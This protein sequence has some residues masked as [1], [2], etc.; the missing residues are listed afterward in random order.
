VDLDVAGGGILGIAEF[1]VEKYEFRDDTSLAA[2]TPE[3][4]V[5]RDRGW[6]VAAG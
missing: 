5:A 2:R 4:A 6:A 1:T 3:R